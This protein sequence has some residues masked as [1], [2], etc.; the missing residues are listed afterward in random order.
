MRL[1]GNIEATQT[2]K[3]LMSKDNTLFP[4]LQSILQFQFQENL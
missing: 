1:N 4:I 3:K 2:K